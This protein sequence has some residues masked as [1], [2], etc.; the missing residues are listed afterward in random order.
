MD[1][2]LQ[3]EFR[4]VFTFMAFSTEKF[5]LATLRYL[6][7][8]YTIFYKLLKNKHLFDNIKWDHLAV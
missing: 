3:E 6:F 4:V 8:P 1:R 7:V 5:L 2:M